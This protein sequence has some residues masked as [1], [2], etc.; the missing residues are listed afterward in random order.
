M[1]NSVVFSLF[2]LILKKFS[3]FFS[4]D[5][6]TVEKICITK[7]YNDYAHLKIKIIGKATE[8]ERNFI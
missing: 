7:A 2:A 6:V 5:I 4:Q 3:T 8:S 1:K